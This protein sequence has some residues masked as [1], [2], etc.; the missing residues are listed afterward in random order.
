MNEEKQIEKIAKIIHGYCRGDCSTCSK[1]DEWKKAERIYNTGFRYV[2]DKVYQT[3]GVRVYEIEVNG[4]IFDSGSVAFDARAIGQ[5]VFL[6]REE[7]E[8][9]IE[10]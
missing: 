4:I 7:A 6:T 5:S 2:P 9:R 8:E 3:D 1:C 10:K